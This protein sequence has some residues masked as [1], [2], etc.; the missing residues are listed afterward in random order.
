MSTPRRRLLFAEVLEGR[1][2]LSAVPIASPIEPSLREPPKWTLVVADFNHDGENDIACLGTCAGKLDMMYSGHCDHDVPEAGITLHNPTRVKVADLNVDGLSDLIVVN[3]GDNTV[4]VYPGGPCGTFQAGLTFLVGENPVNVTV[5]DLNLDGRPDLVVA[6]EGSNDV[7][8]LY[9]R[10]AGRSWSLAPGPHLHT[11]AGPVAVVVT[12]ATYDGLPDLLVAN[13][14]GGNVSLIRGI[15]DGEFDDDHPIFY[16]TG[17]RPIDL[18]VG[19][20]D[21]RPGLD[22]V[23]LDQDTGAISLFSQLS[24]E[25]VIIPTGAQPVA[26]LTGDYNHDGL[27]DLVVA[28]RGDNTVSLHLGGAQGPQMWASMGTSGIAQLDD[29]ALDGFGN[30]KVDVYV[31][32]ANKEMNRITFVLDLDMGSTVLGSSEPTSYTESSDYTPLGIDLFQ[33]VTTLSS[34]NFEP[35]TVPEPFAPSLDAA[36]ELDTLPIQPSSFLLENGED[37]EATVGIYATL[38]SPEVD[39]LFADNGNDNSFLLES[40]ASPFLE[41]LQ[42]A[43]REEREAPA[44]EPMIDSLFDRW[45]PPATPSVDVPILPF[46]QEPE[47]ADESPAL[48]AFLQHPSFALFFL[49]AYTV[50]PRADAHRPRRCRPRARCVG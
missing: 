44:L 5:A 36:M 2:L 10:G 7:A 48:D 43:L 40:E 21:D 35:T 20:F 26:F 9:G 15:G 8:I 28:N 47:E 32:F 6:D 27:Q 38:S 24:S 17:L 23:S 45:L 25:R 16:T 14:D 39:R 18:Q 49:S 42:Q 41:R 1:T 4:V 12:D 11:G 46:D 33:G 30:S 19:E 50:A 3:A 13:G 22:L 31:L 29:I 34:S 37:G